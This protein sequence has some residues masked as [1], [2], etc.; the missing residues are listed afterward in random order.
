MLPENITK[1]EIRYPKEIDQ[2]WV[3]L[4]TG[5][6]DKVQFR[7]L[8]IF[9]GTQRTYSQAIHKDLITLFCQKQIHNTEF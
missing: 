9:Y 3:H 5:A 7:L 2:I 6:E 1:R 4:G 8:E